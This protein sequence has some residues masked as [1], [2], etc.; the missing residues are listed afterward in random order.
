MRK[1]KI[2]TDEDVYAQ[3]APALRRQ[4]IDAESVLEANRFGLEDHEQLDY[5]VNNRR[6]ILTFNRQ[7]YEELAVEYFLKDKK[8]YGIIISPQYKFKE[9]FKRLLVLLKD[10]EANELENQIVYLQS[11]K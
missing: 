10:R 3:L 9:L 6:A 8:H 2:Y 7:H 11:F 4:G 1:A 5:S